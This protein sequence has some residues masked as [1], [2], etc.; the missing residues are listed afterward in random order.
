MWLVHGFAIGKLCGLFWRK[1]AVAVMLS[2]SDEQEK[3]GV[4]GLMVALGLSRNLRMKAIPISYRI[5]LTLEKSVLKHF[6]DWLRVGSHDREAILSRRA[7]L[8]RHAQLL[9][10][11]S[12]SVTAYYLMMTR[13]LAD[14]EKVSW[15]L[16]WGAGPAAAAENL[17]MSRDVALTALQMP[18]EKTRQ[19]RLVNFLFT[20]WLRTAEVPESQ[21]RSVLNSQGDMR[22]GVEDGS[23]SE[24]LAHWLR[25]SMLNEWLT[26]PRPLFTGS[27]DSRERIGSLRRLL[28]Q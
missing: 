1:S 22:T 12:D 9:S 15:M 6:E 18:W 13:T 17:K 5:G 7:E 8:A 24:Q 11:T 10:P 4:D 20:D 14:P 23:T 26:S 25:G 16:D 19:E 27:I 2:L 28:E 21:L 3:A